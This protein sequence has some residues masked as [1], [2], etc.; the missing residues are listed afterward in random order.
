[1]YAFQIMFS[2]PVVS[3]IQLCSIPVFEVGYVGED[4]ARLAM[5]LGLVDLDEA[6][7]VLPLL[8]PP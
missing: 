4:G 6:V 3:L 7:R 1:M 2:G 5:L 8:D